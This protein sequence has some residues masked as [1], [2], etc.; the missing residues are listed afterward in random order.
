MPL[1]P[2]TDTRR[3]NV[4]EIEHDKIRLD[5]KGNS[6][7]FFH[8]FKLAFISSSGLLCSLS[9][10]QFNSCVHHTSRTKTKASQP[11]SY[12]NLIRKLTSSEKKV[13]SFSVLY[14]QRWKKFQWIFNFLNKYDLNIFRRYV[15]LRNL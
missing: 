9:E 3:M 15:C 7:R 14:Q 10:I 8:V 11:H 4:E 2:S 13:R 1:P 6:V 12:F 5:V